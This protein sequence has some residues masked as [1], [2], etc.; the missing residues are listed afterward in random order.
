MKGGCEVVCEIRHY[1]RGAEVHRVDDQAEGVTM[2]GTQKNKRQMDSAHIRATR[3][4]D[5]FHYRWAATRVLDLL[6]PDSELV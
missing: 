2:S 4:G 1:E 3:A 6:N 5:L